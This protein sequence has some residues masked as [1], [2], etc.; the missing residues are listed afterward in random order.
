MAQIF[1]L[2]F[3]IFCANVFKHRTTIKFRAQYKLNALSMDVG[4]CAMVWYCFRVS[5]C[6]P[7]KY[8]FFQQCK[9]VDLIGLFYVVDSAFII[10]NYY[11]YLLLFYFFIS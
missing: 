8:Q 7:F 9:I 5:I 3:D 2:S 11:C 1:L 10:V 6:I 4:V